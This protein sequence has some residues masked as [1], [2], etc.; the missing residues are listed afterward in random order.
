MVKLRL[1]IAAGL[2]AATAGSASA[3]ETGDWAGPYAGLAPV[4]GWGNVDY[5][6]NTNGYYNWAAGDTFSHSVSG[7]PVGVLLGYDWQNGRMVYGVEANIISGFGGISNYDVPSPFYASD[8]FQLKYHWA[9]AT[10]AVVGVSTGRMLFYVQ[11]GPLFGHLIS[12]AAD[13]VADYYIRTG[14]WIVGLTGGAGVEVAVGHGLSITA[15]YRWMY[16]P[17]FNV[18]GES[19]D[20]ATMSSAGPGTATDYS[21][22]YFAQMVTLGFNYRFGLPDATA[23]GM[24]F[25]WAGPY[26]GFGGGAPRQFTAIAGYNFAFGNFVVGVEGATSYIICCGLGVTAD[27]STRAGYTPNGDILF[28]GETGIRYRAGSGLFYTLGGGMEIAIG[29]RTTGFMELAKIGPFGGAGFT[30]TTFRGG[31]N[32]HPF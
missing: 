11:G 3:G 9:T 17:P 16:F 10:T 4:Y 6:F 22:R 8:Q 31:I 13:N 1:L 26:F 25:D 20:R 7:H 23:N 30:E 14:H 5:V 15:G 28:Y 24:S 27:L 12:Q 19:I 18:A 21:A 32:F 2:L 29:Q